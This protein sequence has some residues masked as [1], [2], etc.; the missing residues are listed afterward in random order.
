MGSMGRTGALDGL[1]SGE[2]GETGGGRG[3][4]YSPGKDVWREESERCESCRPVTG[5]ELRTQRPDAYLDEETCLVVEIGGA[6][7]IDCIGLGMRQGKILIMDNVGRR[8]GWKME[9]GRIVVMGCAGEGVGWCCAAVNL[10]T[11]GGPAVSGLKR[12]R[13]FPW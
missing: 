8:L 4:L 13:G 3:G 12:T 9:G 10:P 2:V 11:A 7:G 5:W 1:C 6:E